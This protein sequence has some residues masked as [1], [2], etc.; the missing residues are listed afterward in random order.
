ML[1]IFEE[2]ALEAGKAILKVYRSDCAVSLKQDLSP[3]TV[4][5]ERAEQ[6]ILAHLARRFPEIPVVAE[7]SVAAGH[8]PDVSGKSFFLV[9]PLDGTREF[10]E[11]RD[12]FTVNI[13]YIEDGKPVAG[14]V[15]APAI[16]LA[17]V[18]NDR[19]AEKLTIDAEFRIVERS[20]IK[21]RERTADLL[22]LASRC[23]GNSRTDDFLTDNAVTACTSI[24][25]SLKFCLLAEGKADVYPRFSRTME[26][27]TA[28]GDAV[29]RAAGG[30]TVMTDGQPLRYGKTEQSHDADFANPS[31]IC[32]GG[33]KSVVVA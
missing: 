28:A 20:A 7:E 8:V 31:F 25:S 26:W 23:H 13:A 21:V 18:A 19:K 6:I 27:D 29:L 22:A 3:V 5:D 11:H 30:M 17:F 12:E 24:G 1:A 9:D 4:A 2:A 10:V 14:I 33:K 32:W 15:Y 16:G